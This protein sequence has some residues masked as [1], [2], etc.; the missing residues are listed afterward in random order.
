MAGYNDQT[1]VLPVRLRDTFLA[2]L[3]RDSDAQAN[4]FQVSRRSL[5]F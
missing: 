3:M 5:Q 1:G 2:L 4:V